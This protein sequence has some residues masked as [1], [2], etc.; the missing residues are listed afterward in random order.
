MNF[1]RLALGVT[2][3][4][5]VASPGHAQQVGF[6]D[7]AV[8][9]QTMGINDGRICTGEFSR[10]DIGCAANAPYVSRSTGALGIGTV[11][12]EGV[13]HLVSQTATFVT[14]D[15]PVLGKASVSIG[16]TPV[17]LRFGWTG[18]N[19][20]IYIA[21]P[22][23]YVGI[24]F[25]FDNNGISSTLHVGGGLRI[26]QDTSA[27]TNT[28]DANRAGA[29]RW[30]GTQFQVCYGSGGW[31]TL[32][33]AATSGTAVSGD[34]ITSGTT[35]IVT[36]D[37][38]YTSLTTG[39][40]NTGY[41]DTAGRLVVPG[42]SATTNQT[43]FSTVYASRN[44]GIGAAPTSTAVLLV[45]GTTRLESTVIFT[46][47]AV[48]SGGIGS[49]DLRLTPNNNLEITLAN[50]SKGVALGNTAFSPSSTLHVSGTA[51]FKTAAANNN[52]TADQWGSMRFNDTTKR[53][54]ICRQP[55]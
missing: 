53:L 13:L 42:I 22:S 36:N 24:G 3:A 41:F 48:L 30:N 11:T 39:G 20:G 46:D 50:S 7:V 35:S 45:N 55:E 51:M 32:S 43:S 31:A 10:G 29:M 17:Y 34:R 2:A 18:G 15:R 27:T 9:S 14:M 16:G 40:V 4:L 52:C 37:N 23:S 1:W 26:S 38:G 8:V 5:A 12:P 49:N 25:G 47:K 28:C 6:A 33:S 44:V 21:S 19:N 54:Q